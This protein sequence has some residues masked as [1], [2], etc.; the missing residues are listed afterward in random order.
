M[1]RLYLNCGW[2]ERKRWSEPVRCSISRRMSFIGSTLRT[3]GT[4]SKLFS[5]GGLGMNHSSVL[6]FQGSGPAFGPRFSAHVSET[7]VS[8]TL[9]AIMYEPT[10]EMKL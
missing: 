7:T 3:R 9:S 4:T 1:Y 5:G 8:R 6:A 2:P 10:V